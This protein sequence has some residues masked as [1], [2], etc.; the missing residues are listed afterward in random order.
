MEK[1]PILHLVLADAELELVPREF[2]S[3]PAVVNNARKRKKKPSTV[4]LDSSL[5]HSIFKETEDRNRRGRPDIAYQF[6]LLG[7]DSILNLEGRLRLY[8]HTRNNELISISPETRLPKNFNRYVGLFEELFK[9]GAVPDGKKPLLRLESGR[10]LGS[11][12][13]S[14]RGGNDSGGGWK[15]VLLHPEG[16]QHGFPD[17]REF[18]G[19]REGR[20]ELIVVVGGFSSGDFRSDIRNISDEMISLPGGTLK[21]W[22]VVSEVLVGYRSTIS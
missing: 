7:L 14:I 1:G 8:I 16:K 10:D 6:L 11:V 13:D 4:I 5:H 21:V 9:T 15:V 18:G 20:R 2:W 12:I 22:T 19:G 17:W 3:H